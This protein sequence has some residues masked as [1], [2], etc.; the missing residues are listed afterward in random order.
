MHTNSTLMYVERW[1]PRIIRAI[2]SWPMSSVPNQCPS[3]PGPA[4][5]AL[6][7]WYVYVNPYTYGPTKAK[8]SIS[9]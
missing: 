7:S 8:M 4:D 2:R 9:P 3:V 6:L 1:I 5:S